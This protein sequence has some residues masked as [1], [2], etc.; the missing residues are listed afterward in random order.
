MKT[1]RWIT[2][3]AA[4]AFLFLVSGAFA[5]D[6]KV[7]YDHSFDFSPIKTFSIKIGTPWGNQ[8]SEQRVLD[9]F[10][11]A[12]V[13]KGWTK[14]EEANADAT[15][16]LHGATQQKRDLS[17]FYT[18]TYGGWGYRGW[19]GGMS[20][21]HTTVNEYKV[22]TLVVDIFDTK[23]EKLAFR[24]IAQD[25]L[26]DKPEKNTKKIQKSADKMFKDFPPGSKKK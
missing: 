9:T 18:G 22:G 26:S 13:Q 4:I 20:T 12:L 1:I 23:T 7:D 5:Q 14:T 3:I 24:G 2:S 16:L 17:T 19:G 10:E 8:L 11:A 15:V 25:E 21:A 6:V